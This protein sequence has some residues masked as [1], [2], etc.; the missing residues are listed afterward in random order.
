MADYKYCFID[1]RYRGDTSLYLLTLSDEVFFDTATLITDVEGLKD[2]EGKYTTDFKIDNDYLQCNSE[3]ADVLQNDLVL[4]SK[5]RVIE[6]ENEDSI[7]TF[8]MEGV[9][10]DFLILSDDAYSSGDFTDGYCKFSK[11]QFSKGTMS[12]YC[13]IVKDNK[14]FNKMLITVDCSNIV[15]NSFFFATP[16]DYDFSNSSCDFKKTME[17][18][19]ISYNVWEAKSLL[20]YENNVCLSYSMINKAV[21]M[22]ERYRAVR[23]TVNDIYSKFMPES[24]KMEWVGGNNDYT[25]KYYVFLN[26]SGKKFT[27]TARKDVLNFVMM[28]LEECNYQEFLQKLGKKKSFSALQRFVSAYVAKLMFYLQDNPDSFVTELTHILNKLD[29]SIMQISMYLYRVRLHTLVTK[30][31]LVSTD[32]PIIIGGG[33]QNFTI[34]EEVFQYVN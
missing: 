11:I 18:K 2:L 23:A 9:R 15:M 6:L 10:N 19:G 31:H 14:V 24:D 12:C 34:V 8:F 29:S 3:I 13:K 28:S 16:R 26:S 21:N 25:P 27:A 7:F 33:E 4:K 17:F 5:D 22:L 30:E 20:V 32:C 1:V